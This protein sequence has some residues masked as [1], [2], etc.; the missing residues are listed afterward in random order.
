MFYPVDDN[1]VENHQGKWEKCY[2]SVHVVR[3]FRQISR[4]RYNS[5]DSFFL[6][7]KFNS[8]VIEIREERVIIL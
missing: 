1:P 3:T 6:F 2:T 5:D 8:S 7:G 4:V